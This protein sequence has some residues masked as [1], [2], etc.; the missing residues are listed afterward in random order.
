M[1][2]INFDSLI[3]FIVTKC[4]LIEKVFLA[5]VFISIIC[6]PFVGIN[7]DLSTYL[8]DFAPTKQALDVME[9]EFGYPGLARIMVKD[10]TVQDAKK[11]REEIADVD[12]VSLVIGPD[13]V[14]Q[15]YMSE[16]FIESSLDT[17]NNLMGKGNSFYK[18]NN[19]VM[20]VVF[21][22]GSYDQK[23]RAAVDEIY[24]IC[25]ENACYSGSAIANKERQESV[26]KELTVAIILALIVTFA[27][28]AFT[29]ESWFEP[30]LFIFVMG[31]AIIINMGSNIIFG[32]IS[33][34]TFSISAILQLAVSMDYSIFL[35]HTFKFYTATGMEKKP[36]ME[37][38]LREA[39]S[40][41]SSS[42]ATTIVGFIVMALMRFHIGSDMGFV[43]SKGV[44]CSLL[45]VIFLM[46]SLIIRFT[47]LIDK[48]SHKSFV[49]S[50]NKFS[51]ALYKIHRP[52]LILC[53][54]LI[55]P[56]YTAQSMNKFKFGDEAQGAGP[57]TKVYDDAK[58]IDREF[59]KSNT[60]LA[61]VPTGSVVQ[62][63]NLTDAIDDLGFVNYALSLSGT[64]PKGIPQDFLPDKL[65][66]QFK[67]DDYSRI[68][69][70]MKNSEES[71]YSFACSNTI[72]ETVKRYYPENSYVIGLTPTAMD[73]RDILTV[74]YDR[75]S[76][77]SIIGVA[78]VVM[79]TFKTIFVPILILV[80]IELA[81]FINMAIPYIA[82]E[83]VIYIGYI[84]VS[85][86]QL[87]ATVDYSI[88][89]TNNYLLMRKQY[90]DK[91][92]A[93]VKAI[94]KSALSILTSASILTVVGYIIYFTSSIRS[95]S[96]V[97]HMVGRGA[98]LSM[99]LVL[100]LLPALLS[101]FDKIII[102]QI[103]RSEEKKQRK[104]MRKNS[105]NQNINAP[106]A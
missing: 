87:G 84:I 27:I 96:Q 31:I 21:E 18:N 102:K 81:T 76:L 29:T 19:A 85:C 82:G 6:Y 23:T 35:L 42:G 44:I 37:A 38:A 61:I 15:A 40:S 36:A 9:E 54:L 17:F 24:E 60:I 93:A 25:G 67:T 48:F 50:F 7:Y 4:G 14:T 68:I 64:L 100:I 91:K 26:V 74:D 33:F 90:P 30:V 89:M 70:S 10:V 51:K 55:I 12:G 78:L 47:P 105:K 72:S 66:E 73:I 95:I 45:T 16:S 75:V 62:E 39:F 104:L 80:P 58:E 65:T 71:D 98:L 49:P 92:E 69:I 34:F 41:I 86:V 101:F 77:F 103:K 3:N 13:S 56:C 99:A 57:G 32:E 83:N 20:D 8:P 106:Q 5:A 43:L 63:R 94:S 53:A 2:K 79:I 59:G 1:R 22:E 88:L 97:G 11:I 28:L 52:V 46:P